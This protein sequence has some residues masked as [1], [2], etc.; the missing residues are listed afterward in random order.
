VAD[1]Q[2]QLDEKLAELRRT[3]DQQGRRPTTSAALPVFFAYQSTGPQP[4]VAGVNVVLDAVV[5][6]SEG[7]RDT[8]GEPDTAVAADRYL[9]RSSGLYVVSGVGAFASVA[10]GNRAA[11]LRKNGVGV[12]GSTGQTPV[13][14]TASPVAVATPTVVLPLVAGDYLQLAVISTVTVS[15]LTTGTTQSSLYIQKIRIKTEED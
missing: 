11:W 2:S 12:P 3:Q 4:T 5:W 10:S 6:D 7:G 1:E 15:T 13:P 9:C 14:T 8:R